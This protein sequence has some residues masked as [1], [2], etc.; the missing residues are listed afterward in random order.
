MT[1]LKRQEHEGKRVLT[2]T[3]DCISKN[4]KSTAALSNVSACALSGEVTGLLGENGAGKSTLLRILGGTLV[5]DAGQVV[6]DGKKV[7]L[8]ERRQST[9]VLFGGNVG[10]YEDLSARDNIL[11]FAHLR[12]MGTKESTQELMRLSEQFDMRDYL[13]VRAGSLSKGMAQKTAIV[14]ALIHSPKV[15]LFDE[16]ESGLDFNASKLVNDFL[17]NSAREGKTVVISSHSAGDIIT[18][19]SQSIVLH[20]GAIKGAYSID[21]LTQGRTFQESYEALHELVN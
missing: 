15:I 7:S 1:L 20:K 11:Y 3:A 18:I 5:Q 2:I 8:S 19:C 21:E 6:I 9:T 16:P 13:D 14:R 17:K 4:F 12:G 10:L